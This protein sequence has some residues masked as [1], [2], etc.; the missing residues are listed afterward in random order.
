MRL[1][2]S[3]RAISRRVVAAILGAQVAFAAGS[4]LA[5]PALWVVR[6]PTATVYLFGTVHMLPSKTQWHSPTI[7]RA[8]ASSGEVWTEADSGTLPSLVRLIRRYGLSPDKNLISV[9]PKRYRARYDMEMSSAGLSVDQYGH[10]KPWLATM[11]LDGGTLHRT[12]IGFG[13]ETDLLAY[14][15]THHKR[16]PTFETADEQFSILSDLPIASQA[17]ALELQIE[18]YPSANGQMNGLVRSWLAGDDATVDRLSNQPLA[19]SDSRYFD[20]VIVRRNENF[21]QAIATRL[22]GSGTAFV[23]IGA[24]HLCGRDDIQYFLHNYGLTAERLA[25]SSKP[26]GPRS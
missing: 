23:A 25:S 20:D 15:R 10:V 24:A 4:A 3:I 18:G 12:H 21:A 8:L 14:A 1:H 22:Q 7:D 9:L 6:S 13:V 26:A 5:E 16:T 11:L 2:Q 17:R 19:E